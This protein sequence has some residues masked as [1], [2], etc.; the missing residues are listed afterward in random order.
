[1]TDGL[2]QYYRC[3]ERY[4]RFA[5]MTPLSIGSGYFKFGAKATCYGNYFGHKPT[6]APAGTL[7]D[8]VC[9][10]T[11]KDGIVYLPFD[12]SQV[13]HNLRCELYTSDGGIRTALRPSPRFIISFGRFFRFGYEGT[14][15]NYA[16]VVG[17]ICNFLSGQWI[18]RWIIY[19]RSCF[20]CL[21]NRTRWNVFHSFGFGRKVLRVLLL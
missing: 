3:P 9:D 20:R 17:R 18:V 14:C 16:C 21:C 12:P 6:E 4:I 10:T 19:L 13:A 8:A 15:R 11:I 7:H 2:V 5:P 1:M